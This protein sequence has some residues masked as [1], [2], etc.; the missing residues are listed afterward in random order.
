MTPTIGW[1]ELPKHFTV[2]LPE[3]NVLSGAV[4]GWF[5]DGLV[6]NAVELPTS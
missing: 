5:V 6:D 3:D 1:R 2:D 4:D